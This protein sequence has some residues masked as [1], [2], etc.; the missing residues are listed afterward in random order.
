MPSMIKRVCRRRRSLLSSHC[1][2]SPESFHGEHLS[3]DAVGYEAAGYYSLLDRMASRVPPTP[4]ARMNGMALRSHLRYSPPC[5]MCSST[6]AT[7]PNDMPVS[8]LP[9]GSSRQPFFLGAWPVGFHQVLSDDF[10]TMGY[11]MHRLDRDVCPHSVMMTTTPIM[12]CALMPHLRSTHAHPPQRG[13]A[14]SMTTGSVLRQLHSTQAKLQ[15]QR[16]GQRRQ[17]RQ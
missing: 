11:H 12:K 6:P 14:Q 7:Q 8:F 15:H 13:R 17:R 10:Q 4:S 5:H 1:Q 2:W 16:R 3:Q 9:S